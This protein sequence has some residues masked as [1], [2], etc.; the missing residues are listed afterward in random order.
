MKKY[1]I[2]VLIALFFITF[3]PVFAENQMAA[4]ASSQEVVA[5]LP[6]LIPEYQLPYPGLLP[7][8]P[9]YFLKTF[10]DRIID[11]LVSSPLK[12]AELDLLQADKRLAASIEL[13]AEGKY[14]LAESTISKGENYF[15]DAVSKAKEAKKQGMDTKGVYAKLALSAQK[16]QDVLTDLEKK[17]PSDI[18]NKFHKLVIRMANL[19]KQ[20]SKNSL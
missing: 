19:K 18:K 1:I 10:R 8:N 16:H 12:K 14:D 6:T 17:A 4:S 2:F 7:D 15:D 20:V 9:L 13:A 5:I 3:R 11:F